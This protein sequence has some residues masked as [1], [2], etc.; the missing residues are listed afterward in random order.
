MSC[1][2][3]A[4]AEAS[5][6]IGERELAVALPQTARLPILNLQGTYGEAAELVAHG[7]CA[8]GFEWGSCT[9]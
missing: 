6:R 1:S 3:P 5:N 8:R 4:T 9:W 2:K 7:G